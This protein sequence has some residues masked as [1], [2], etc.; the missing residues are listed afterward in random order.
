MGVVGGLVRV[1][2]EFPGLHVKELERVLNTRRVS[3]VL[4]GLERRGLVR[5]L[6]L[7]RVVGCPARARPVR[8][9]FPGDTVDPGL[10]FLSTWIRTHDC[11]VG[12]DVVGEPGFL[13][14]TLHGWF[15]R[16][17]VRDLVYSLRVFGFRIVFP[18][19]L[20]RRGWTEY[21]VIR[22]PVEVGDVWGGR[23]A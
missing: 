11:V 4:R 19:G 10:D 2:R 17:V 7:V 15:S 6:W 21:V 16:D 8:A 20:Y 5:G 3:R 14:V 18:R 23:R 22:V 9:V 13:V 1:V 12:V